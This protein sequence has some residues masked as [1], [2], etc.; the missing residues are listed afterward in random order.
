[1]KKRPRPRPAVV[2]LDHRQMDLPLFDGPA[3][4]SAPPASPVPAAPPSPPEA[5]AAP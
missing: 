1:M 2:A 5:V 3:A 4:S